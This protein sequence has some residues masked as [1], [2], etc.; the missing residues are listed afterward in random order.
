[1]L[2]VFLDPQKLRLVVIG[3]RGGHGTVL[4]H[5]EIDER[6]GF[7]AGL[8][9]PFTPRTPRYATQN[10]QNVKRVGVALADEAPQL[11]RESF[12]IS[13]VTDACSCELL[14]PIQNLR[15]RFGGG[16]A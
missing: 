7:A 3:Q 4:A 5:D 8:G 1:M 6:R 16:I 10:V 11:R 14:L 15:R 9:K 13:C 2:G 12:C